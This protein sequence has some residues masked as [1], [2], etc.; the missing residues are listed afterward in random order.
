MATWLEQLKLSELSFVD[1]PANQLAKVT[2]FK[3]DTSGDGGGGEPDAGD[4]RL[5]KLAERVEALMA[6]APSS[7]GNERVSKLADKLA[8][9]KKRAESL[10]A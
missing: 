1:R 3:R 9:M 5:E 2:I 6:K 4:K 10:P 7:E 8:E